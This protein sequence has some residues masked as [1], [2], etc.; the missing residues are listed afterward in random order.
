MRDLTGKTWSEATTE[1]K[2][3]LL[4]FSNPISGIDGKLVSNG[5]CIV[6]FAGLD[7]SI[8][9]TVLND[10]ILIDDDAIFYNPIV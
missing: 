9:G 6:D 7:F 8:C 5:E 2:E 3:T 10:E 4:I 1:E